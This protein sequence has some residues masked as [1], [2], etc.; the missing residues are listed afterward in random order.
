MNLAIVDRRVHKTMRPDAVF[1]KVVMVDEK[2]LLH[3][4]ITGIRAELT[5]FHSVLE[6]MRID[7]HA[8]A[9]HMQLCKEGVDPVLAT[10][11]FGRLNGLF[12][13]HGLI[14]LQGCSI[15]TRHSGSRPFSL[16]MF[17]MAVACRTFVL[18]SSDP[19]FPT[20]NDSS[21]D[22]WEGYL[23]L[24]S[25]SG[26]FYSMPHPG[27]RLGLTFKEFRNSFGDP[28][29]EAT[30]GRIWAAMFPEGRAWE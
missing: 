13:P 28:M 9:D 4:M 15:A 11:E 10:L 12:V 8:R 22:P 14:I 18:A 2:T 20:P 21:I 24:C 17:N 30:M 3:D 1:A 27:K 23:A 5:M 7:S 16:L 26:R 19:Q 25:P 6:M 29:P